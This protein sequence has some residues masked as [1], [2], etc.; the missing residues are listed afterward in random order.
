[1]LAADDYPGFRSCV[2]SSQW[3]PVLFEI[4]NRRHQPSLR[5]EKH[6][7]VDCSINEGPHWSEVAAAG[8]RQVVT[9]QRRPGSTPVSPEGVSDK[10][11]HV[12]IYATWRTRN[13]GRAAYLRHTRTL[14][15]RH[16][17]TASIHATTRCFYHSTWTASRWRCTVSIPF[18]VP[19]P[20]SRRRNLPEFGEPFHLTT[21]LL[22]TLVPCYP[23]FALSWPSRYLGNH[24]R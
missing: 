9:I 5:A 18:S 15:S 8:P 2:C 17:I 16:S 19:L 6:S 14:K 3:A 11:C 1:M 4:R 22:L 20:L 24:A 21:T 13:T 12:L 10:Q 7:P 23:R